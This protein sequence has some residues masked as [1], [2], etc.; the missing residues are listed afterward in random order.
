MLEWIEFKY[1]MK[2]LSFSSPSV[3][4]MKLTKGLKLRFAMFEDAVKV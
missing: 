4:T 3:Q 2:V 1:S